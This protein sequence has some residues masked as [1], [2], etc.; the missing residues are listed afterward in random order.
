MDVEKG[1]NCSQVILHGH[2]F[3]SSITRLR[4]RCRSL[5]SESQLTTSGSDFGNEKS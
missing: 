4:S 3:Y 2:G 1:E 5:W